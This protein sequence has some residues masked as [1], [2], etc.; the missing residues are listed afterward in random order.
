M[1]LVRSRALLIV[2]ASLFFAFLLWL[3][4]REP[5]GNVR[6]HS[7][8]ANATDM[9]ALSFPT[10]HL[11]IHDAGAR[12]YSVTL[13]NASISADKR[14]VTSTSVRDGV[15]YEG[16]SIAARFSAGAARFSRI[17]QDLD[18]TGPIEVKAVNGVRLNCGALHYS[19]ATKK[20]YVAGPLEIATA[21]TAFTAGQM[22]GDLALN[23]L[24]FGSTPKQPVMLTAR[25]GVLGKLQEIVP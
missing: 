25:P 13:L 1:R 12:Q 7:D 22:Q 10:L 24:T 23:E 4:F 3:L 17:S 9:G 21:R 19:Y 6:R 5:S 2:A 11:Y 15:F 14:S 18:L 20:L 16:K 8:A